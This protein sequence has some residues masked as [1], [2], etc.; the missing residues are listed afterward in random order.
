[1]LHWDAACI[2]FCSGKAVSVTYSECVFVALVIRHAMRMRH[3]SCQAVQYFS[4]LFHNQ[5]NFFKKKKV[6]EHKMCV[7]ISF[8]NFIWNIYHSKKNWAR[9]DHK[10]TFVF[11]YSSH[12]SCQILALI[13]LTWRI[14]WAPN[15]ASRLQMGFNLPFKGLTNLE[16]S[17][18]IFEKYWNIKFLKKV[19]WDQS[20]STRTNGRTWR[21]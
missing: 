12:Y 11:M 13:L 14:R 18:H 8:T 20:P 10:C 2:H 15:N 5:H 16:F 9:Y 1:M 4:T 3:V 7:L 6:I 17:R 21:G 19:Q